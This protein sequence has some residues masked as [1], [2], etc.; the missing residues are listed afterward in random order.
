MLQGHIENSNKT[1]KL[2]CL[3]LGGEEWQKAKLLAHFEGRSVSSYIRELIKE[4][5][6]KNKKKIEMGEEEA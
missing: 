5:F 6:K 4:A 1:T 2:R 3:V